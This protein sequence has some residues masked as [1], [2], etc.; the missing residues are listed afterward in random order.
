MRTQLR[1]LSLGAGIQS[2]T[3]ALMIEKGEGLFRRSDLCRRKIGEPK[4]V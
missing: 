4:A 3:L 2:S 1:V